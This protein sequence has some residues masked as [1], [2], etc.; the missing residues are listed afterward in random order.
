MDPVFQGQADTKR[1]AR[2]EVG[3][4][5]CFRGLWSRWE[6]AHSVTT[7]AVSGKLLCA[8]MTNSMNQFV[9]HCAVDIRKSR[10]K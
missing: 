4:Q 5:I 3:E 2:E 8:V 6:H 9:S 7:T 1:S 10:T